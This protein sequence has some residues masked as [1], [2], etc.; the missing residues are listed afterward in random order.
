MEWCQAWSGVGESEDGS[1][2]SGDLNI[3]A[4]GVFIEKEHCC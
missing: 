3:R 1:V 4:A 2:N